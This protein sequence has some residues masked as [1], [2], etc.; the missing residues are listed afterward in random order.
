MTWKTIAC[1]CS[2]AKSLLRVKN[3]LRAD[4]GNLHP[5]G[6]SGVMAPWDLNL[7]CQSWW[8]RQT[9]WS[10]FGPHRW[11]GTTRNL[12][13]TIP[14]N[15]L[16]P[17]NLWNLALAYSTWEVMAIW[18]LYLASES[19]WARQTGWSVYGM[20]RDAGWLIED[21]RFKQ[22]ASTH[23]EELAKLRYGNFGKPEDI[24]ERLKSHVPA[25]RDFSAQSLT[26]GFKKPDP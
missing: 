18:D 3:V 16:A 12:E 10:V 5:P 1:R 24:I 23:D 2:R 22:L 13:G 9:G 20:I 4:W 11:W 17:R 26:Q 6:K 19:W 7:E 25:F 8:A 15:N 21:S 14:W